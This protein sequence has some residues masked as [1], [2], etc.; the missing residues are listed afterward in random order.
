MSQHSVTKKV[1]TILIISIIL[2]LAFLIIKPIIF[3]IV[4]GLLLAYLFTPVYITIRHY[5]KYRFLSAVV[6]VIALAFLIALPIMYFTPLLVKQTFDIYASIQNYDSA[7]LLTQFVEPGIAQ[8][9]SAHFNNIIG[10]IFTALL[11]TSTNLLI[12]LPSVLLQFAVFLFTFFFA[13]KDAEELKRYFLTLSPFPE[14]TEKKFMKEFR[15]ITNAIVF[16]QVLI[17]VIQGLALGAGLF[18]LGVPRALI[19]TFITAVVSIIPILGSWLVWLPV[20]LVLLING[21]TFSG[22]FLLL[23]GGLFV[24]TVDNLIRPYLL[25][26]QSNLPIALSV[27]GTIGGLYVFGILGLILGPLILAYVLIV[28]EMYQ[29]G[30]LDELF[31]KH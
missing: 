28:F 31:E 21:D 11:N 7:K 1:I 15:G 14:A 16:G 12:D 9:I 19:L 4:F 29:Q 6:L 2:I 26:K 3:A 25:S 23:Y 5:L 17:G 10:K 13:L 24:S 27:I 18:F 30:K 20:G 22:V 8:S